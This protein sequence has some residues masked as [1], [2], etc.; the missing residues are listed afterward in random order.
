MKLKDLVEINLSF[1]RD[2]GVVITYLGTEL[3]NSESNDN[4]ISGADISPAE[5]PARIPLVGQVYI[6][7]VPQ[8]KG[9]ALSLFPA[10]DPKKA[11]PKVDRSNAEIIDD[12]AFD[13]RGDK[14]YVY[15]G[16][17]NTPESIEPSGINL[18][19][20][21][22]Q[23]DLSEINLLT[24]VL[25]EEFDKRLKTLKEVLKEKGCFGLTRYQV[26]L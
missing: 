6:E 20:L 23:D 24:V 5:W 9:L 18:A 21:T 7:A 25:Y 19:E 4:G 10:Y 22:K 15:H 14:V 2:V 3:V 13:I 8:D 11:N 1:G 26:N 16:K 17:L 12:L